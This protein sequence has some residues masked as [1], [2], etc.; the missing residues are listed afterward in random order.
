MP[1]LQLIINICDIILHFEETPGQQLEYH[2]NMESFPLN[3]LI[4][5]YTVYGVATSQVTA[6][7]LTSLPYLRR[8]RKI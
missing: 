3:H 1:Y 6:I 2:E 7:Y 8:F 4:V 5:P